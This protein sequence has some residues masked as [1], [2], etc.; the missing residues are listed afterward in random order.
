VLAGV[1]E[2]VFEVMFE[3]E[4]GL[5]PVGGG[6]VFAYVVAPAPAPT[7][8]PPTPVLLGSDCDCACGSDCDPEAE[9]GAVAPAVAVAFGW[10]TVFLQSVQRQRSAQAAPAYIN[11]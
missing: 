1:D 10:S 7:P 5:L 2:E 3:V 9:A 8:V 11:V 6:E 4:I